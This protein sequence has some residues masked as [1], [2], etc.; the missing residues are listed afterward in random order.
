MNAILLISIFI[1]SILIFAI[2]F[3][4][5]SKVK[6]HINLPNNEVINSNY[7]LPNSIKLNDECN[8]LI[9][10]TKV[11]EELNNLPEITDSKI[12]KKIKSILKI[13]HPTYLQH[14]LK[15]NFLKHPPKRF[16]EYF[17]LK[18]NP[19]AIFQFLKP[20]LQYPSPINH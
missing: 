9:D 12:L 11:T 10:Q 2:I 3:I 6:E 15:N 17:L 18:T 4:H 20:I 5:K 7:P 8:I 13:V 16:Y 14:H 19:K 1:V